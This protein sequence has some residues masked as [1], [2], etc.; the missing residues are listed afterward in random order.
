MGQI[1]VYAFFKNK[2]LSGN[3][4]YFTVDTVRKELRS[5]GLDYSRSVIND[6]VKKL[7]WFGYLEISNKVLKVLGRKNFESFRLKSEYV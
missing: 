4:N 6:D 1:E 3:N 2:R 7:Y 5:K